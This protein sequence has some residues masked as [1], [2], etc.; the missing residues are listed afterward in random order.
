VTGQSPF[1]VR[2]DAVLLDADCLHHPTCRPRH[3]AFRSWRA[4]GVLLILL[5]VVSGCRGCRREEDAETRRKR[6]AQAAQAEKERRE[7]EKPPLELQRLAVLPAPGSGL[8]VW[9]KPGHWTAVAL[10]AQARQADLVCD[11]SLTPLGP[12]GEQVG[13]PAVPYGVSSARSF[14]LAKGQTK[15]PEAA[16][17]L[18]TAPQA[19]TRLGSAVTLTRGLRGHFEQQHAVRAMAGHQYYLAVVARRP[20]AYAYLNSLRLLL[21]PVS[22]SLTSREPY[23]RVVRYSVDHRPGLPAA[24]LLWTS[25]AATIWD[26]VPKDLLDAGQ[27]QALLDWLHWGGTVILSG[28]ETLDELRD[29][30]LGPY[31]PATTAGTLE[32]TG[33]AVAELDRTWT[34]DDGRQRGRGLKLLR[35]WSGAKLQLHPAARTLP[36]TGGLI[37]ERRVGRGRVVASAFH[38]SAHEFVRWPGAD[39]VI[40]GCLLGRPGRSFQRPAETLSPT[41]MALAGAK[42]DALEWD[43]TWQGDL[44]HP[45]D[46]RHSSGLRYLT[47]DLGGDLQRKPAANTAADEP[48]Y[49]SGL[50]TAPTPSVAAWND[51]SPVAAA[52]RAALT[53]AA[54][55]EIPHR[56]FVVWIVAGYLVV[57]V[58]VNWLLFRLLGRTEWA[59]A[60]APLIA[61]GW[62]VLVVRLAQLDVGFVR[63]QTEIGLV[64]AQAGYSRAHV[65][66]YHAVYTSLATTY[67][68]RVADD[69]A[70]LV[71]PFP[72]VTQPDQFRLLPGQRLGMLRERR[73]EETRVDGL[74]VSSSTTSLLHSEQMVDLG[75]S[76]TL[77]DDRG[78]TVTLS[79]GTRWALEDAAL[80][81]RAAEST[82]EVAWVGN[83]PAG[84][85]LPIRWRTVSG[86]AALRPWAEQ[87]DLQP[88]TVAEPGQL[89]VRP[90]IDV[91]ERSDWLEPGETRLIGRIAEAVGGPIIEPRAAQRTTAVVLVV[92]LGYGPGRDPQPDRYARGLLSPAD[93]KEEAEAAK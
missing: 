79:N 84:A 29:S 32:L 6:E 87:R 70:A 46:P 23:Y 33:A 3:A 66:R 57:L 69:P 82:R 74:A 4:V 91:V 68:M 43:M 90:V 30:F 47:R 34:P 21:P 16:I 61:L 25:I 26:D 1:L 65:T 78:R 62:T 93:A 92:H 53:T 24:A 7:R 13:L 42:D 45:L 76:V 48:L 27:Q 88:L 28:P 51:F 80:I 38:L 9:Y 63:T 59:W 86:E 64:E 85:S 20:D 58:P 35:P 12:T 14:A 11:W 31:L 55:V 56:N 50:E 49:L 72:S 67:R 44:S 8:A 41:L 17:F 10:T 40:S 2:A 15:S 71:F 39:G 36:G 75:G 73:D 81:R 18:P 22:A 19:I 5:V 37:V 60:A 52:A 77:K 83:L 54:R 89:N